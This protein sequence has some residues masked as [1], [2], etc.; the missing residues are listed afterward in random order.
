LVPT[1]VAIPTLKSASSIVVEFTTNSVPSTYRSPL[2]L[3]R[4]V[5]S[6][7]PA[8]S[9]MISSGPIILFVLIPIPSV[10]P[11][12]TVDVVLSNVK[13][14]EAPATPSSLKMI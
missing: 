8:G 10:P 6:P 4:P 11:M 5:L 14:A 2:I 13:L 12:L 1:V 7:T 3:T 9:I